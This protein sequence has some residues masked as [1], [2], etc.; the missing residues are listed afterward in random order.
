MQ[1]LIDAAALLLSGLGLDLPGQEFSKTKMYVE[2]D[3]K[4]RL[5][6]VSLGM[7]LQWIA[8]LL[9][10]H[11]TR[12]RTAWR[13]PLDMLAPDRKA[14][15]IGTVTNFPRRMRRVSATLLVLA[16]CT[17][18]GTA[19]ELAERPL[20]NEDFLTLAAAGIPHQVIVAKIESSETNFD[21]S[22]EALLELSEAGLHADVLTAMTSAG[23]EA[24]DES[25][26]AP[27]AGAA[28]GALTVQRQASLAANA[29]TNF[30]DT[31][32]EGPG[33]YLRDDDA[34][35]FLEPTTIS[36]KQTGGGILSSMTYGI[37]S[38]K[39]RAAIRGARANVRIENAQPKFLFCFEE[40]QT[41]LSYITTGAVNPSEF[42]L[43]RLQVNKRKRQRSFVVGKINQWTGTRAGATPEE[44]RD[45]KSDR[46]KPGVYEAEP[47]ND[48]KPGKYAFY[49]A[50]DNP[51]GTSDGGSTGKL[52][53]FGLD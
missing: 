11:W 9:V 28:A 37:K 53:A 2:R 41:G 24:A 23:N 29:A 49:F 36:Q 43:V 51:L 46:I 4:L 50:G 15:R 27:A 31:D 39:A 45:L 47:V 22:V 6:S 16:A 14:S 32:C 26:P 20:S 12:L 21:T 1:I 38:V 33:I 18:V 25:F 17:V 52:F 7:R 3:Q 48:L 8:H 34:L 35:K 44:L 19:Q 5:V 40:S 30:E 10:S 13:D 42:L